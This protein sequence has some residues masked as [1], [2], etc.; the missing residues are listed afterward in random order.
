MDI[1]TVSDYENLDTEMQHKALVHEALHL[2]HGN[3]SNLIRELLKEY[4][5]HVARALLVATEQQANGGSVG[6]VKLGQPT[7]KGHKRYF[8]W[9]GPDEHYGDIAI[10]DLSGA[11]PDKTEDGTL[12][13]D[14]NRKISVDKDY[15]SVPVYIDG[16][17]REGLRTG[18]TFVDLLWLL[19]KNH[20]RCEQIVIEKDLR[21]MSELLQFVGFDAE[22]N[23]AVRD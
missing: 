1:E 6:W 16:S 4:P 10:A 13:I 17:E 8:V 7:G 5:D 14:H 11:T 23:D 12:W 18:V 19:K 2:V 15:V 20:I 9:Y 3:P 21:P 22:V